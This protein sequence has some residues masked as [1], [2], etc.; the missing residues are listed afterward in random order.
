MSRSRSELTAVVGIGASVVAAAFILAGSLHWMTL[1]GALILA[2]VSPGAG[3]MCWIDVGEH[4]A[5][6]GL[7][8]TVSLALFA[9]ASAIM[10]WLPAWHPLALL[11]LA[12]VS[13]VSC[14][15]RLVVRPHRLGAA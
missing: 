15:A 2:C 13:A 8:L 10:I 1:S 14:L 7:T 4:A 5:Q 11:G 12:G 3:V 6:A 9:I